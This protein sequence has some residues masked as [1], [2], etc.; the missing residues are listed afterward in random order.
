ML[1][2]PRIEGYAIISREGMIALS[3]GSFPEPLKIP[4]DQRFYHG[5]VDR[6]SAVANGRHSAEGGPKES[7]RKRLRI[8]RRVQRIVTDP[9]NANVVLW[10]PG[11]ASFPEAWEK[12]GID[13]GT[14]AV[15]GGTDVF[16]LFL[17]IGYDVFYL[18]R[19]SGVSVRHG[20][21]VFPGVGDGT[22]PEEPLSRQGFVLRSKKLLD[23]DTETVL[24][25]W[26]PG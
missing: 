9:D 16:A 17:A 24:E 7:L 1:K 26:G 12:L 21:P 3:D 25:E 4:A 19:A 14:L 22:A 8:T 18:S 11:T 13:G 2:R 6:A 5:A 23:P 10:N 20:R 15:V